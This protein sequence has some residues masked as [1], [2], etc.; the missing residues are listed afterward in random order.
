VTGLLEPL[1]LAV[2]GCLLGSFLATAALRWPEERSVLTGRSMCDGCG[3]VLRAHE[4]V[5]LLSALG[6]RGRCRTCGGRI[7]PLHWRVELA[8]LVVG[9]CA[10]WAADGAEAWAGAAFGWL[11]LL[12]A[13]LDLRALWLPDRVTATL[14]LGGLATGAAGLAPPMTDRLIGGASGFGA[15]WA[16]AAGYR[17]WRGRDGMGGGDPKLLGAVGLWLGWR[18]LP[19]V[20]TAAA[21]IGLAA[22]AAMAVLGR[23]VDR[24]TALPLGA[25]MAAAAYPAWLLTLCRPS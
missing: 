24:H 7:D 21:L 12:L 5:P 13:A 11:L 10:G 6:A 8:G 1:L 23:R 18:P 20:V 9:L 2:L 4:L 16:M 15:L 19:A 25:L 14:A 22:A 17:R 3:R